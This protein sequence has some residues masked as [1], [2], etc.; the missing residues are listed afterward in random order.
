MSEYLNVGFDLEYAIAKNKEFA[1]ILNLPNSIPDEAIEL[2]PQLA[3]G[4]P[5]SINRAF[6]VEFVDGVQYLQIQLGFAAHEVNGVYDWYTHEEIHKRLYPVFREEPH[7]LFRGI[8]APVNNGVLDKYTDTE[9]YGL[10]HPQAL[11]LSRKGR[12]KQTKDRDIN[13]IVIH[14]GGRDP[15]HLHRYFSN[16]KKSVSSHYATGTTG[17]YQM[18]DH[19]VEAFHAGSATRKVNGKNRKLSMNKHSIGI[20]LCQFP[21]EERLTWYNRDNSSENA[22]VHVIQNKERALA[23]NRGLRR[24]LS[25]DARTARNGAALIEALCAL[26]GLPIV[27]PKDSQNKTTL[28]VLDYDTL[29]AMVRGED[30]A[31]TIVAH[32]HLSRTKPDIIG[33]WN[34][35]FH[36]INSTE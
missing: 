35:V 22:K 31:P 9:F 1:P 19:D 3:T 17:V 29:N 27:V 34:S 30:G 21:Q 2:S 14:W 7:M 24:M 4:D 8:R 5:C 20:D 32:S 6:N 18:L 28:K 25:L 10:D 33:W 13:F 23:G 36:N 26:H 11:D 16:V 15:I 12:Y